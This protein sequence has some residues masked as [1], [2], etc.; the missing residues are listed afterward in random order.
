MSFSTLSI[1]ILAVVAL[2]LQFVHIVLSLNQTNSYLQH[3][4]IK[5]E[6]TY[7]PDSSYENQIK[8]HLDYSSTNYLD[9]GFIHGV[10]GEGPNT[11]YIK[12]QCRGD[13]SLSMC[14]SCLST[15]F[16]GILRKCRN[17]KGRIIWY[18]NCF[19]YLS[20]IYTYQK[21][22]SKHYLYLQNA[23]DVS[24]NTKL[25]NKNKRD[26]LYKL[27]GTATRKEQKPYT[28]DYMYATGEESLGKMKLYAMMQCTQDLS[29]KNCSVCLDSIIAKLPS[30]CNGKQGGRVLNPSCTFRYELYPF[31][32]PSQ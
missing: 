14:R 24:G 7:N 1:S 20:S 2:Q 4:C 31:V 21:I 15:A 18:D 8:R 27:K 19:L 28:R 5:S 29:V 17:N 26:L 32:K 23:K 6:G 25:F 16:S 12:A 13:A 9:Y 3:I 30:C 10:G 22:D 11:F